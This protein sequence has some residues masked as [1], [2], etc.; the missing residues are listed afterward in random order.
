[1]DNNQC[2]DCLQRSGDLTF[3]R[4][5]QCV[6]RQ[7]RAADRDPRT[8]LITYAQHFYQRAEDFDDELGRVPKKI[9]RRVRFNRDSSIAAARAIERQARRLTS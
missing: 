5:K 2:P 3:H 7:Q 9:R 6:M 1:M 8:L 4:E